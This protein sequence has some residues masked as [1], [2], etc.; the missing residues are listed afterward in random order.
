MKQELNKI[1]KNDRETTL[2]SL[3]Y[4]ASPTFDSF[5]KDSA[6]E[7]RTPKIIPRQRYYLQSQSTPTYVSLKDAAFLMN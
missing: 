5:E 4:F 1:T 7:K 6:E 3:Y 2:R